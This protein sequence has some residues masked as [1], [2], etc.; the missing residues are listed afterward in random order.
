MAISGVSTAAPSVKFLTH[1][2]R[3]EI[4]VFEGYLV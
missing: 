4:D 3:F 1:I 2:K